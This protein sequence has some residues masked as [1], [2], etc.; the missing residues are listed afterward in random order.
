M[1]S[2]YKPMPNY[3]AC[4]HMR[5]IIQGSSQ[6]S[7]PYTPAHTPVCPVG[8]DT[9]TCEYEKMVLRQSTLALHLDLAQTLKSGSER[10]KDIAPLASVKATSLQGTVV[11][12]P[13]KP[14][15]YMPPSPPAS[16]ARTCPHMIQMPL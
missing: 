13:I 12:P 1:R 6:I 3:I 11:T 9:R 5:C 15:P 7:D 16:T 10:A 4:F 2:R 14:L 8:D